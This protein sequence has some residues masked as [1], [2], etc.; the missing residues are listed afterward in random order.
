LI[1]RARWTLL[2]GLI[3]A[4]AL[5]ATVATAASSYTLKLKASPSPAPQ[6]GSFTITASG[7]AA[8]PVHLQVFVNTTKSCASTAS[9][10]SHTSGDTAAFSATV[11]HSFSK[12]G[13]L[14]T[15]SNVNKPD[16]P[17]N[18]YACAYLT[19]GSTTRAHTSTS[20]SVKKPHGGGG[21]Y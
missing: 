2:C 11:K 5:T 21:G 18:H 17:G 3:A 13:T 12:N 1:R 15:T 14:V 9:S 10:E 20:Y 6:P 7:T 8:G 19:A 4:L 16:G